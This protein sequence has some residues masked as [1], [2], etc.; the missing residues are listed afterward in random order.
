MEVIAEAAAVLALD[1]E[2]RAEQAT[3]QAERD[4]WLRKADEWWSQA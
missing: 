3:D 2:K 4:M 1:A